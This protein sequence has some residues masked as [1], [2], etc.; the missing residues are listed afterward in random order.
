[1]NKAGSI[2]FLAAVAL[3]NGVYS[4]TRHAADVRATHELNRTTSGTVQRDIRNG[5]AA[6]DVASVLGS[7]NN[8]FA[9]TSTELLC[10]RVTG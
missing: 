1:M 9:T 2:A 6:A 7:P 8:L 10:S 3:L 5:M 4:A